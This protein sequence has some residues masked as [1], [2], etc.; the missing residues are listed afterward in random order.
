MH[1]QALSS[2]V[3]EWME[4]GQNLLGVYITWN[5]LCP[6]WVRREK[7]KWLLLI[8]NKLCKHRESYILLLFI[9]S[10][11]STK[12]KTKKS[13]LRSNLPLL[14]IRDNAPKKSLA[15][16]LVSLKGYLLLM[17]FSVILP[18]TCFCHFFLSSWWNCVLG[19]LMLEKPTM[20]PTSSLLTGSGSLHSSLPKMRSLR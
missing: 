6:Q 5:Y 10:P 17:C 19:W 11:D 20:Q 2:A 15:L 7:K 4:N 8:T 13:I 12:N 14:L 3:W 1:I 9:F 18:N 16:F